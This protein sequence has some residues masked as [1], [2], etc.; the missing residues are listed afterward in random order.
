MS[1]SGSGVG[2]GGGWT[3]GEEGSAL[4]PCHLN[5]VAPAHVQSSSGPRPEV[6]GM[7]A[8]T[9]ELRARLGRPCGCQRPGG[10]GG[11]PQLGLLGP[12]RLGGDPGPGCSGVWSPRRREGSQSWSF[13]Q[14][15]QQVVRTRAHR[16]PAVVGQPVGRTEPDFPFSSNFHHSSS[17]IVV[18]Y[19]LIVHFYGPQGEFVLLLREAGSLA[20]CTGYSVCLSRS[21]STLL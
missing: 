19:L 2:R 1:F 10:A 16:G 15:P 5:R 9:P 21:I 18:V 20:S 17:P 8:A 14:T 4:D 11:V 7:V 12:S 6:L 13:S 3:R